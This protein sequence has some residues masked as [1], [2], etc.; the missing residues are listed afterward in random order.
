MPI[1]RFEAQKSRICRIADGMFPECYVLFSTDDIPRSFSMH[2]SDATGAKRLCLFSVN[3][4]VETLE[5]M[6]DEQLANRLR[7]NAEG[8]ETIQMS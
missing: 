1:E 5:D 7:T 8:W 3:T 4:A 2:I 6:S